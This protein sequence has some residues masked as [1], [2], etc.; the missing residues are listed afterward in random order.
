MELSLN[1]KR[2]YVIAKPHGVTTH[3]MTLDR[4]AISS[5]QERKISH[6]HAHAELIEIVYSL[7]FKLWFAKL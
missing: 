6:L 2:R 5:L 1:W 7:T 4:Q 3:R